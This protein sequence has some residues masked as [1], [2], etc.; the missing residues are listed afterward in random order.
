[1]TSEPNISSQQEHHLQQEH[2]PCAMYEKNTV[3]AA[4]H[5]ASLVVANAA[6]D[7]EPRPKTTSATPT[8]TAAVSILVDDRPKRPLSA[9]N[10]FFRDARQTLLASLPVR[11]QGVPRRSHGKMGFAEMARTISQQ[12]NALDAASREPYDRLGRQERDLYQQRMAAWKAKSGGQTSR[13]NSNNKNNKSNK[14]HKKQEAETMETTTTNQQEI[15]ATIATTVCSSSSSSVPYNVQVPPLVCTQVTATE[16]PKQQEEE[17]EMPLSSWSSSA[18]TTTSGTDSSPSLDDEDDPLYYWYGEKQHDQHVLSSITTMTSNS[19]DPLSRNYQQPNGNPDR[20]EQQQQQKSGPP[21]HQKPFSARE[22]VKEY[23]GSSDP[24]HSHYY[25][26]DDNDDAL[27]PLPRN[28]N[29][30]DS[31]EGIAPQ[32][33]IKEP[34]NTEDSGCWN[35]GN[36]DNDSLLSG[37]LLD[38]LETSET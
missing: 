8:V 27:V 32:L 5:N 14:K 28:D 25:T 9:Y 15:V 7:Q 31:R 24:F 36:H 3:V 37:L 12:W 26:C 23:Y 10:L 29:H 35:D 6:Q 22:A 4:A 17:M 20:P 11:P 16:K 13:N 33:W 21:F 1:M 30:K 18:T 19:N 34:T 38:I 2:H